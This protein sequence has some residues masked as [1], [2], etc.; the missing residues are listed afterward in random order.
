MLSL[1]L[2]S[3]SVML[4]KLAVWVLGSLLLISPTLALAQTVNASSLSSAASECLSP[5]AGTDPAVTQQACN[6]L[7]QELIVVITALI[8]NQHSTAPSATIDQSSLTTS[9]LS[10]TITGTASGVS[11]VYIQVI[12]LSSADPAGT[13]EEGPTPVTVTNGDWSTGTLY[14]KGGFTPGTYT[15]SIENGVNGPLLTSGTLTLGT[16]TIN[17]QTNPVTITSFT[18]SHTNVS[19]GQSVI[20]SWSSNLTQ[21]DISQNGG[22]CYIFSPSINNGMEINFGSAS[23]GPSGSFTY[24]PPATATYTLDCSS[25]AKD[26]SPTATK[27]LTVTVNANVVQTGTLSVSADPSSPVYQI[28]AGGTSGVVMGVYK[29][30]ATGEAFGL[31]QFS[32]SLASGSVGD[33]SQLYLY[34]NSSL[35]GTM[36]L[37]P[38]P[39]ANY[40]GARTYTSTFIDHKVN[41]SAGGSAQLTVKADIAAVGAGQ[42]G[43][44]GDLIQLNPIGVA[45]AD[46]SG[47][48]VASGPASGTVAG[49]RIFKSYPTVSLLSLPSSILLNGSNALLRFS[50]TASSQGSIGLQ[51]LFFKGSAVGAT[52]SN[53]QIHVFTDSNFSQPAVTG[54]GNGMMGSGWASGQTLAD[55][56]SGFAASDPR[57][58]EIPAGTTY[59][60]EV[61]GNVSIT[62]ATPTV[63]M[64]L[65]NEDTSYKPLQVY[66]SSY[67][68]GFADFVWSPNDQTTSSLTNSDW[69]DG[70]RI[71]G[72]PQ[73]GISQ[74]V[75]GTAP[76]TLAPT[77]F[78]TVSP[79]PSV[80][81]QL[82]TINVSSTNTTGA[83]WVQNSDYL[84]LQSHLGNLIPTGGSVGDVFLGVAPGVRNL[85]AVFQGAGGSS[86]TCPFT[87]NL[88]APA[89]ASSTSTA[90]WTGP[91]QFDGSS[92]LAALS[93]PIVLAPSFTISAWVDPSSVSQ[94]SFLFGVGG[95]ILDAGEDGAHGY[96]LG[97]S[98]GNKLWWWPYGAGDVF[99]KQS[100]PLNTWTHVAL[101]Y[102]GTYARM[103]INGVLDSTTKAGAPGIPS[104]TKIG[105]KSWITGY[106]AGSI[107][108][109]AI[110]ASALSDAQ[111]S[112]L[113]ATTPAPNA[114]TT[115]DNSSGGPGNSGSAGGGVASQT[116]SALEAMQLILLDAQH[117]LQH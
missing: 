23:Y 59:F 26:G 107:A 79:T 74:T 115:P 109:V 37:D 40:T 88:V 10:P 3:D 2:L 20:F 80:I 21:N 65:E 45:G 60:F 19:A 63:A 44:S 16:N 31:Y 101:T 46:A 1:L 112:Q 113:Y 55:Y 114:P 92:T 61:R 98:S 12:S 103:Y 66:S 87:L 77:C 41:V 81:G 85:S 116:A 72:L 8:A 58:T 105:A 91:Q 102:D 57:P 73:T 93:S 104:F 28:V 39:A 53:V 56:A 43:T 22:G 62:G 36:Q 100:I 69:T 51:G 70:Y 94:H 34:S 47:N 95:T 71:V 99:S 4:K 82:T 6:T 15:V 18:A 35:V 49:V 30:Q 52:V 42:A 89:A 64:S 97:I 110:S 117:W 17:T 75:T 108:D 84:A 76:T 68:Q 50:V 11:S 33:I 38:P 48:D 83:Q 111:V 29:V 54:M 13:V 9:S 32:V 90:S 25:G 24:L 96:A 106:F 5:A 78:I 7:I 14:G 67:G 27:S 86:V